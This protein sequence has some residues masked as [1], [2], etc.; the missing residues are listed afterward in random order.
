MAFMMLRSP[1]KMIN[2]FKHYVYNSS[3]FNQY[4]LMRDDVLHV[5]PEVEEALRRIPK[6]IRDER[7]FRLFRA[8]QL[9]MNRSILPEEQ[10]TKLEEDVLYLTPYVKE[11]IKENEEKIQWD[12]E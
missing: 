1:Y 2:S 11:V 12:K 6:H 7:N 8:M 9:D 5:T 3:R 10:W 4:G